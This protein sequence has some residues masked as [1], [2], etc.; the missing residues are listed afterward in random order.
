MVGR[1]GGRD[2]PSVEQDHCHVKSGPDMRVEMVMS[3]HT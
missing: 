3:E 2:G 1:D